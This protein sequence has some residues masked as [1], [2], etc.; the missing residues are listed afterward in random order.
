MRSAKLLRTPTYTDN[1]KSSFLKFINGNVS[2]ILIWSIENNV[3][4][5][6]ALFGLWLE[7]Y[8]KACNEY[9]EELAATKKPGY[10][11]LLWSSIIGTTDKRAESSATA[12]GRVLLNSSN[13]TDLTSEIYQESYEVDNDNDSSEVNQ[14]VI[15]AHDI[16]LELLHSFVAKKI[17]GK[18]RDNDKRK[19]S[20]LADSSLDLDPDNI[21]LMDELTN[22][23]TDL[24]ALLI[25]IKAK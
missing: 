19:A 2:K 7:R 10:N 9:N 5:G 15:R 8:N 4:T 1:E 24:D 14:I 6:S 18:L 22:E 23:C 11:P 13:N 12:E 16:S 25:R 17:L 21:E 3:Q 20:T